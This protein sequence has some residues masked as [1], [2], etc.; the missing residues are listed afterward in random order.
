MPTA[1]ITPHDRRFK[2][3][4]PIEMNQLVTGN[5]IYSLMNH[6]IEA[7]ID[8]GEG[9]VLSSPYYLGFDTM[10]TKRV[11]GRLFGVELDDLAASS[12]G[13]T[14]EEL[15]EETIIRYERRIEQ[16]RHDGV[17]VRRRVY[18]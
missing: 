2:A 1:S 8:D 15:V 9:I 12:S 13:M 10:C 11:G 6:L 17:R 18:L 4:Q 16:C 5:G 14:D 3:H 7:L